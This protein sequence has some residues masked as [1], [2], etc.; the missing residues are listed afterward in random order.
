MSGMRSPNLYGPGDNYHST[1]SHVLPALIRR[2]H[3]A[4]EANV[5]TVTCWGSGSPLQHVDD[6]GEAC[7]Y[8]IHKVSLLI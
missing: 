2:F 8:A 1:N 5:E 4:V 3:E 6:L 7:V